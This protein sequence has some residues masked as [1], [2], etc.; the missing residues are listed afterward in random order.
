MADTCRL[1]LES[2]AVSLDISSI[3][4]HLLVF[5]ENGRAILLNFRLEEVAKLQLPIQ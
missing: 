1:Q 2:Q 3:V 4:G 5:L